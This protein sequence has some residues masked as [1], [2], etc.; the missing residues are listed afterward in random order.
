MYSIDSPQ[1]TQLKTRV[2]VMPGLS[3]SKF[4]KK[5]GSLLTIIIPILALSGC[6][7]GDGQTK[8]LGTAA[9]PLPPIQPG[10]S[11]DAINF[12]SACPSL[13]S[14]TEFEGGPITIID[15][16][17]VDANNDSARVGQMQKFAADSGATFGG[18]TMGLSTP[19][20]VVAGSSFT[21]KVWSQR[22]VRVLFQPEP[23]GP[24]SG[25]EVTHG[26]TGWE[27]LTFDFGNLTGTVSGITLIFD[28]G[29][30]GNA[31]A[32]P[33]NWTFYFDDIT[34]VSPGGGSGGASI[35]PDV[36]LY[37]TD[38]NETVDLVLDVDY[39]ETTFGS[40]SVVNRSFADD[41]SY[42]PV[43]AVSSGVG[44]GANIAQIGFIEFDPG[45][46][47]F[48]ENLIFKVK[49]MPNFVIF[50]QLYEGGNRVRV[51][52]SSS[53]FSTALDDGWY[54]VSIPVSSFTGVTSATGIVFESD[55]TSPM[56]FTFFLTDIGF[57]GTGDG[58]DGGDGG[59]C[60]V[61]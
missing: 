20:N 4:V 38:P 44:Y 21:M 60:G 55:D 26:G 50:V 40:Q 45:F 56:Q 3:I 36:V 1:E 35:V 7:E 14:I 51:N 30:L 57:S 10:A 49:G 43:L 12:E 32:D 42:N 9:T 13:A 15:N 24:G 16:P 2:F 28:N 33:V 46:V 58:G 48:Y 52:L 11:C 47:T 29:V 53:S 27:V 8:I 22:S 41:A 34:L 54:Q 6:G 31:G 39:T 18:S 23:A 25:V 61:R 17:Q 37:A 19:F 5:V 59:D